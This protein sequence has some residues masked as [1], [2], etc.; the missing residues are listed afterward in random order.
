MP[1]PVPVK[2][3]YIPL[4]PAPPRPPSKVR[5]KNKYSVPTREKKEKEERRFK[6]VAL[7]VVLPVVLTGGAWHASH[8]IGRIVGHTAEDGGP[9]GSGWTA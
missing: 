6:T 1:V 7:P 8:R 2:R 3:E 5:P 9:H 4:A